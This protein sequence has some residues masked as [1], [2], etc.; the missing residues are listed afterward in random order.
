MAAFPCQRRPWL[1]VL[2]VAVTLWA[3]QPVAAQEVAAQE[4]P[5]A[6]KWPRASLHEAATS[7][8]PGQPVPI[9]DAP[10]ALVPVPSGLS[11]PPS[12]PVSNVPDAARAPA[13]QVPTVQIQ[14]PSNVLTA[15]WEDAFFI[16]S[17]NKDFVLRIT[18]Q[19]QADYREYLENH[20]TT[21]VSRFLLRRARLGVEADLLTY[22]EFRILPDFGQGQSRIQ[23][24]YL[25]IHYVDDLQIEAGRFKQPFSY[26]QLIQDRYVPT[27]ERS[28][29]DQLV[30]ARDIGLMLHGKKLLG[31]RLDWAVSVSNGEING[32][33]DTNGNKDLNYRLALRPFKGIEAL[34]FAQRLQIGFA[35]SVGKEQE[36]VVP[37]TLTTPLGVRWFTYNSTVR[38]D[39]MRTRYSPELVYFLGGFGFASQYFHQEQQLRPSSVG[40]GSR[41]QIDVP[42]EGFYVLATYLLTGE[43]RTEYTQQIAPLR[44]FDPMQPFTSPGA[45]EVVARVSRLHEGSQAFASGIRNLSDHR[46]S[47]SGATETTLGFNWYLNKWVRMQFNWEHAWFNDPVQLGDGPFGRLKHQDTLA[48]R[49]QVIF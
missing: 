32:D 47:S 7:A 2:A 34:D 11:G 26:E 15:G 48:T 43:E 12:D 21:D 9:A 33:T 41:L 49:F 14:L 24:A 20:D 17:A 42:T 35:Q 18:G 22:Y 8:L 1:T 6:A 3:A 23:D 40:P 46:F 5:T 29:I 44:P 30:P 39:G 31:D 27:L 37:N 36:P 45:L 4:S 10:P 16:R 19:I 28:M 25:N 13:G 38:A